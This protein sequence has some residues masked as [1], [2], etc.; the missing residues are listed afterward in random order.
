MGR[1]FLPGLTSAF[2]GPGLSITR[3]A[4]GK[5][6]HLKAEGKENGVEFAAHVKALPQAP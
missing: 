2:P 4:D 6:R 5:T 1:S 3:E